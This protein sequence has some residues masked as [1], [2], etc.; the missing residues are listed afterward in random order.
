VAKFASGRVAETRAQF[1]PRPSDYSE[2]R[3]PVARETTVVVR[4]DLS[5]QIV[6]EGEAV[7]ISIEFADRR[8][9]RV[10]IDAAEH[11]VADW[12]AKGREIK[13]RGRKPGSRNR[14][15]D[16]EV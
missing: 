4:S 16:A 3:N 12:L 9:N 10:E 1:E 7:V 5:G 6:P 13:R 2:E 15:K 8:R 14:P 11:E